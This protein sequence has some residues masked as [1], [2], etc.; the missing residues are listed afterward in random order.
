MEIPLPLLR[1][2]VGTK[3]TLTVI[4]GEEVVHVEIPREKLGGAA[5]AIRERE[6]PVE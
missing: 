6:E 4:R 3:V 5:A 2:P 1:G